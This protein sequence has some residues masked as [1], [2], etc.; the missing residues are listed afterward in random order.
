MINEDD[1]NSE[2]FLPMINLSKQHNEILKTLQRDSRL[3][4]EEVKTKRDKLK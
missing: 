1:Y 4:D 3:T 2:K